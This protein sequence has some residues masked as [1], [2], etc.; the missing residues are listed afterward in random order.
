MAIMAIPSRALMMPSYASRKRTDNATIMNRASLLICSNLTIMGV[1]TAQV[2]MI[3]VALD[4][5]APMTL[6]TD[7]EPTPSNP[8]ITPRTNSGR[9]VPRA[10]IVRPMTSGGTPR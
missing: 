7:S 10:T 6:P 2:P 9:E 4:M 8:D 5:L 1:R 3:N